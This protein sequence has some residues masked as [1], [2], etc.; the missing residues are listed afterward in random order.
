MCYSQ[1]AK[2]VTELKMDLNDGTKVSERLDEFLGCIFLH[3][4]CMIS[5]SIYKYMVF[6]QH[7]P[8][9]LQPIYDQAV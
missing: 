2:Y 9:T 1:L 6:A 3:I 5:L 7:L 8:A 4:L